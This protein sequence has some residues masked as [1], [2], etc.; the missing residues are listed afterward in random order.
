[1]TATHIL[2]L[3]GAYFIVLLLISHFTGK[4]DSNVDFFKAGKQSPWYLVAFGMIGAS[5]SG[6]TFISV[7]GWVEASEFSYMQVVFGYSLGYIVV[8]YVLLPIYYKQNVTSIYEYLDERFGFVSYKVGAISFFVSRVLG[9]AFRL[10]LVAIVLQQFVFDT[11]NVPFELTVTLSILLIWIYTFKGGI[12][13][14]VWTD[15]LQTLFML[16]SVGLSIF[17]IL[18]QLDWSFMDFLSS[19]ELKQY[20]KTWFLDDFSAKNHLIKSFL[21]GMFIT[22]CMT[23]LDQDMMQKNLTCKTL[24]DAQKNMISFSIVLVAV[25]FIFMLLGA[26][27]FIFAE[28]SQIQVPLMDG[29][30]K[31]DL[32]FPEIAL[33]SGLGM[34]VATTFI[35]GLI[36]AAY[37]SADSALTSLTTSFCVDFLGIGHKPENKRKKIRKI[38]HIGMSLLLI[39]VVIA[40]KHIL[41]TNVID[42]LLQVASYT[43]G[44]LL[45]LFA[46]GIFT[47]YQIKDKYVWIVALVSVAICY[48]LGKLPPE[49]LGGYVFGYELLPL[50]GLI[51]FIGLLLLRRK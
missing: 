23:G 51:T 44:P 10:F 22:I 6:V 19:S 41:D 13:T 49:N 43:Y 34:T 42:G 1:M 35:L 2:L 29:K 26:L 33:N 50:N 40:F 9:A 37:S 47:K 38:T 12:K 20:N 5:L 45:G 48:I 11:W 32:L 36:A 24:K 7:P 17:F 25:T 4:N 14:I 31:P 15:T 39:L 18:K 46:F 27:L 30:P 28:K 3:I 16:V 8:A 21:G